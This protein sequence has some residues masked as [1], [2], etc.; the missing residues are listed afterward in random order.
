M[1]HDITRQTLHDIL[2]GMFTNIVEYETIPDD[3]INLTRDIRCCIEEEFDEDESGTITVRVEEI[4]GDDR[5]PYDTL[6]ED[7]YELTELNEEEIIEAIGDALGLPFIGNG[8][9]IKTLE[10]SIFSRSFVYENSTA[11][12]E[13]LQFV[14]ERDTALY[15]HLLETEYDEMGAND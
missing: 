12:R 6:F 11:F 4:T 7:E 15:Q 5:F 1:R 14:K 9:R 8:E 3:P 2:S 10:E 13:A